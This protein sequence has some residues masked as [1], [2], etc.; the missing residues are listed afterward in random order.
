VGIFIG[1]KWVRG[2]PEFLGSHRDRK[3]GRSRD[4]HL[5]KSPKWCST[6][7]APRDSGGRYFS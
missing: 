3:R 5:E 1:A 7:P 2:A 6:A 4:H